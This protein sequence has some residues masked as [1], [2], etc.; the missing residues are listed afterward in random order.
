MTVLEAIRARR[1]V[2]SYDPRPIPPE[3]V[4]RLCEAIRLAP[5]ACNLQPWKFI[6]V[7]DAE[8]KSELARAAKEQWF[9]A[10]APLIIVGCGYPSQ[11]YKYTGGYGNSVDIDVAIAID[12]LT[13][14]AVEEGL[15]TCWIGAFNENEVKR[16]LGIPDEVKVVAMTPVGYPGSPDLIGPA[17]MPE[18]KR[19]D[20]TIAH[21]RWE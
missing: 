19:I 1:S 2:R 3:V 17:R 9:I 8:I 10:E 14:A 11:A 16:L 4:E 20:E 7:T 13:L 12:H 18:R 15:G 21:E 5:S 6:L